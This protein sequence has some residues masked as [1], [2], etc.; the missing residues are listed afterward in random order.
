MITD[1][2]LFDLPDGMT[3]DNALDRMIEE[4]RAPAY[5]AEYAKLRTR[6]YQ[7]GPIVAST[8]RR[9]PTSG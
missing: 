6:L 7:D 3:L 8:I 1:I 9:A 4:T 5:V 2:V